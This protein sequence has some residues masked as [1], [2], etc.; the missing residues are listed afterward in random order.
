M[1]DT[2]KL[3][4]GICWREDKQLFMARFTF[5]GKT[6]TFYDKDLKKITKT[7]E[8]KKYEIQH[9]L[10]GTA[11]KIS[12]D[13]WFNEWLNQY[14]S[15]SIKETSF[16]HYQ[17]LYSCYV[18]AALGKKH[19]SK[20]KPVHVQRLVNDMAQR[21]LS[22]GTIQSTKALLVAV[23][24]A[25]V[26]NDL[27]L[28]NACVGVNLPSAQ[29]EE[30][31]VLSLDE[32]AKLLAHIEKERWQG[33]AP[34]FIIMLGAGLRLGEALG[35]TWDNVDFETREIVVEK[36]LI[37]IKDRKDGVSKFKFQSPKSEASKR[38]IPLVKEVADALKSQRIAQMRLRSALGQKWKSVDGFELLVFTTSKGTPIQET[39]VRKVLNKIVEEINEEEKARAQAEEREP[40]IMEHVHPHSLRH[41]FATRAIENHMQ[42]KTLQRILGH[43]KLEL[44]MNLYVH[45]T[46]EKQREDMD[47]LEGVFS[48]PKICNLV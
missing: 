33:Y 13:T 14:K 9:G 5:E 47:L 4:K 23:F 15:S 46:K 18:Q 43:S 29:A 32:Q 37:Y 1:V 7:L 20:I 16:V 2:K 38:T 27:V 48:V 41:S 11:D 17:N 34:L 22:V 44:T 12:L 31:R 39:R 8:N 42:A 6:H 40:I 30:P 3:P 21:G 45:S 28:K 35:L 24:Q 26:Q 25:A 10:A 19:L 36:T